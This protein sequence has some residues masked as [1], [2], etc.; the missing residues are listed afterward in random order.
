MW[1]F[2]SIRAL[3]IKYLCV[4][5]GPVDKVVLGRDFDVPQW[6]PEAYLAI[7]DRPEPLTLDEGDRLGVKDVIRISQAREAMRTRRVTS[8]TQVREIVGRKLSV[9][10]PPIPQPDRSVPRP[11]TA[12]TA[13]ADFVSHFAAY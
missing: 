9:D 8:T 3:A 2:A 1:G 6:L 11:L 10:L 7:C 12:P 13:P 4:I 5:A